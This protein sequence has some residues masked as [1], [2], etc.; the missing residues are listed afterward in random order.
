MRLEAVSEPKKHLAKMIIYRMTQKDRK[1]MQ[2]HLMYDLLECSNPV[3]CLLTTIY[4]S[5]FIG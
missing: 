4:N 2:S 3:A 1:F 5:K